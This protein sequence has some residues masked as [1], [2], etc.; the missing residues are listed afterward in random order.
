MV[1]V[2]LLKK[3]DAI[4]KDIKN[5]GRNNKLISVKSHGSNINLHPLIIKLL[6]S[7]KTVIKND[8]GFDEV[9]NILMK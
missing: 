8:Y 7:G 6:C 2:K 3:F 4:L 5:N 9:F 1:K